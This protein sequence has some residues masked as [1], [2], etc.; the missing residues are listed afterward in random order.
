MEI[1][2]SSLNVNG[3]RSDGSIP[4]R[5][6]I[7]TWLKSGAADI[8]FL[9]ETYSDPNTGIFWEREWGGR[10][11]FSHGSIRSCGVAVLFRPGLNV[12]T[13]QVIRDDNGR[14]IIVQ[15]QIG[16][17]KCLL[18]NIY[19]PNRDNPQFFENVFLKCEGIDYEYFI[20]AG[21]F[22][23]GLDANLDRSSSARR[24]VNSQN[25]ANVIKGFMQQNEIVDVWRAL[26]PQKRQYTCLRYSPIFKSRI[27]YFLVS[28][29]CMNQ[30]ITPKASI[31]DGYLSDHKRVDF[32]SYLG[33][34]GV[35]K[36][37]WR[38][39]DTWLGD[40]ILVEKIR[41]LIR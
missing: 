41:Q 24:M 9:Q 35:G 29:N 13:E 36:A 3:L 39:N 18:V 25:S 15:A 27:D 33:N 5:R 22:N 12:N 7:F 10:I 4:K 40:D 20:A 34:N 26:H 17:A 30:V 14:F 23:L 1:K 21:D 19:G 8:I 37:Y 6:K 28:Q 38:F 2:F 11:I 32:Q 16:S 31:N